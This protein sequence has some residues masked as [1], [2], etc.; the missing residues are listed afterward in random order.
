[1]NQKKSLSL[2][3]LKYIGKKYKIPMY[4]SM[5]K[6]DLITKI[7]DYLEHMRKN[8]QTIMNEKK[9]VIIIETWWYK[10]NYLCWF[11]LEPLK[12][13]DPF[14]I[15]EPENN[16]PFYFHPKRYANY[17]IESLNFSNPVTSRDLTFIEIKRLQKMNASSFPKLYETWLDRFSLKQKKEIFENEISFYEDNMMNKV[18][19]TIHD[20]ITFSE[21]L[22]SGKPENLSVFNKI[23]DEDEEE[24]EETHC[25]PEHVSD[26]LSEVFIYC[27]TAIIQQEIVEMCVSFTKFIELLFFLH[28]NEKKD[29]YEYLRFL[30][31]N[32]ISQASGDPAKPNYTMINPKVYKYFT[33]GIKIVFDQ[34]LPSPE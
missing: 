8:S 19:N 16:K 11:N 27:S 25:A 21:K 28:V 5:K 23:S 26:S 15:V 33:R 14:V 30:K 1:M 20:M 29:P 2:K 22:F 9:A 7:L 6:A 3:E 31:K 18:D 10:V 17:M 34:F 12:Y 13:S 24:E 32:I 4:Y